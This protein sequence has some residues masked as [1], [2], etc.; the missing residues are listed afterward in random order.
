M[1]TEPPKRLYRLEDNGTTFTILFLGGNVSVPRDVGEF[2]MD[3]QV[4]KP[5]S[6]ARVRIDKHSAQIEFWGDRTKGL[7]EDVARQISD[8]FNGLGR[9]T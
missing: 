6:F 4:G 3:P 8:A 7:P 2:L 9:P 1:S 5:C